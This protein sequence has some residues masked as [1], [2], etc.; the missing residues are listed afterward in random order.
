MTIRPPE[1]IPG[2]ADVVVRSG[3]RRYYALRI[4]S[5]CRWSGGARFAP[6]P[7]VP[8]R[9]GMRR[10]LAATC[11]MMTAGTHRSASRRWARGAATLTV[12]VPALPQRNAGMQ[13]M[14][15]LMLAVFLLVLVSA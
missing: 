11:W 9:A 2:V 5:R 15:A 12:L 7:D 6:T 3:D 4:G 13:T 1:V 10:C 14:L 8:M